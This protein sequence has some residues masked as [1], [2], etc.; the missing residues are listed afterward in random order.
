[1]ETLHIQLQSFFEWLLRTTLQASLLICLIMLIQAMLR[2]KLGIRW[3]YGLWLLLLVRMILPWSPQSRVSLYNFIPQPVPQ[4]QTEDTRPGTSEKSV[5]TDVSVTGTAES[6]PASSTTAAKENLLPESKNEIESMPDS[7]TSVVS[8]TPDVVT[9]EPVVI[10]EVDNHIDLSEIAGI[11]PIVWLVGTLVLAV[12]IGASNFNL[13]RIVKRRHPLTDQKI[14]DLLED[15]K[16]RMGIQTILGIV[17]TDKVQSPALFGFVR[18]RLLLPQK[19][20]DTLSQQEL[21]YVLLHELAH[22]KR[23]DI[24]IGWLMSLLQVMHWFNPLIWLAFYR[25]RS[26]REL[27]CDALVLSHS[28]SGEPKSYGRIIVGL[29]ER[30]SRAQRLP[31]M[32]GILESKT[33]LKRRI[34]MIAKYKKNS[35][36]W[37]PLAIIMMILLACVSLPNAINTKASQISTAKS[38]PPITLRRMWSNSYPVTDGEPSPDGR[39]LSYTDWETGDLA[40]YEIA[41]GKKRRLTNKGTWDDS[42][43]TAYSSRWSPDGQQI[44]YSWEMGPDSVELR[45]IRL[46]GSEPR[47]LYRTDEQHRWVGPCDWFPDGRHI[48]VSLTAKDGTDKLVRIS[49]ADGSFHLFKT[50]GKDCLHNARLSPDGQYI[51]YDF[52]PEDDD[53]SL[54]LDI[55]LIS[56]DATRETSL[57]KHASVD[58]VLGWT[59]DGKNI[60]F[61]SD[62]TGT[63]GIWLI[64]V[65]D[66]TPRGTPELI[67]QVAGRFEP[68]GFTREGS[69]YYS[70]SRG[71]DDI[72]IARIEPETGI[73][74]APPKKAVERYEGSNLTAAYSSDGNYIAYIHRLGYVPPNRSRGNVLCIRSLETGREREFSLNLSNIIRYSSLRWSPD[75]R[76]I[77]ICG[78]NY[79]DGGGIYRVDVQ[80]GDVK[81]LVRSN[82]CEWS[83]DGKN[84]IYRSGDPER[85]VMQIMMRNLE[86]GNEEVLYSSPSDEFIFNIALSPDGRFLALRHIR[87][88]SLK[89]LPVAGGEAHELPEFEKMASVHKPIAWTADSKYILFSGNESGGGKNPLYRISVETGKTEKLGLQMNHYYGLSAHPD[90]QHVLISGSESAPASEVWVM[91]N[92]LPETPVPKPERQITLRQV[93]SS[94]EA[95]ASGGP[96]PDGKYLSCTDW[97]TGDLAIR[98]L[99][100]GKI[101]LLTKTKKGGLEK[102]FR[103]ALNSVIS[104]DGKLI[105]YSW[106]NQYG[107]YDLC[108]IGTDGSGDRTLYS[109][110][111]YEFYPACWSSDG[112]RIAARRYG[113]GGRTD[114]V[115][116]L[117]EDGSIQVLKTSEKPFW[118]QLCYSPNDKFFVF[119]FPVEANSGN[120]DIT[121]LDTQTGSEIPLVKHPANDRLLGWIPNSDKVLFLSDRSGT[122]DV[123]V[124][125]VINGEVKGLP[126]LIMR[127]VG[128]ISPQGLTHN[129]SLFFNKYTRQWTTEVIPFDSKTG[130]IRDESRKPLLGSNFGVEWSPDGQH[131]SYIEEQTEPEGPGYHY[132]WPLHIRNIKTGEERI[133]AV[134]FNVRTPHWSPDGRSILVTGFDTNRVGQE[135]Y[136]GGIYKIDVR[137]GQVTQLV[138]FPP[139]RPV[140]W[141]QSTAEWSLDGKAIF[142]LAPSGIVKR[143]LDSG[144]E[145]QLYKSSVLGR[146]LDLSPDGKTLAFCEGMPDLRTMRI[147]TI[148]VS[149]GEPTELCKLQEPKGGLQVPVNITWTPDGNY[150]L[151]EKKEGKGCSVCRVFYGGGEPE[152]I[153]ESEDRVAALSMHPNGEEIA[154]STYLQEFSIWV[155]ENFLP[156]VAASA[157]N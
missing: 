33:Q 142:Y 35:Y 21:R 18:P 130:K 108:V 39:Y 109:S 20:I 120:L 9:T 5:S 157:G 64:A 112:K 97:K 4:Q 81:Y 95:D 113:G 116:V 50:V 74:T 79:K 59:P 99:A 134:N 29:V 111:D 44:V 76:S 145:E 127:D 46:D 48:L 67:K 68:M 54:N 28:Q 139:E 49:T 63:L 143:E 85:K 96:S 146:A 52:K 78:Y 27:A 75:G 45:L 22:L 101:R 24:Y 30:F 83:N 31:A 6:M 138:Q 37:S 53:S 141:N 70:T 125:R 57:I 58:F 23:H 117:V 154:V 73:V 13:W 152:V 140:G 155:M 91:E 115:S 41:T 132:H 151:F 62:R 129:G 47:T 94:P 128:Q 86:D 124:V 17:L 110:K 72:Y 107:T 43:E 137:D 150:V 135:D 60:L 69:Y 11:F 51:A 71:S 12:Y 80:T 104:P 147:M 133:L 15:C 118:P 10:P 55:S 131:L 82:V 16:D 156:E 123:W 106:T 56:T 3:H 90:G 14:L 114:I 26:D 77:L 25:I 65:A 2:G 103:F 87:P 105:A 93:W 148:P 119:D 136:R 121:M 7:T 100:T 38:A 98:E 34:T 153:W 88:T 126:R 32:A 102:F 61:A 1:M 8:E 149:G 36:Q 42:D 89:I 122:Q 144:R 66:G 19:M 84:I 92:F 40:V